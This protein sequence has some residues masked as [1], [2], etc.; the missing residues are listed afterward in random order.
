[1]KAHTALRI[2][3]LSLFALL[4]AACAAPAATP[5]TVEKV[6][7]VEKPVVVTAQVTQVVEQQVVVTPTPLPKTG[8]TVNYGLLFSP[9][10]MDPHIG[11]SWDLA[12]AV[13]NVYDPL[14]NTD[15]SGNLAPGL[16]QSWTVSPDARSITFK[17]RQG[18]K[19]HDGTP[20]NA[21]A[22]KFSLD[23]IADPKT[24]SEFAISLI[25][26]Y[27]STE[28]LDDYTARVN[29]VRPYAPFLANLSLP[30][31]AMVSPAA[32]AK[33]GA[34]YQMHQVGTGPYIFKEYVPDQTL[35]LVRNPD[36][37]WAP[38]SAQHQ[39]AAY[40]D[41]IVFKFIPDE[42]ARIKALQAGD[43]NVARELPPEQAPQ[44]AQD[45]QF[46][47]LV[48]AEP[49]QTLQFFMNTKRAP[50]D[51]LRV[52]Q[53]LLYAID[54]RIAANTIF[55]G[56]F[57]V[58]YGPLAQNT[59]GYDPSL[60]DMYP[61]DLAKAKALLQ[62]A[63]WV[64]NG[65]GVRQKNGTTL[66]LDVIVQNWGHIEE[67]SQLMQGELQ[68]VGVKLNLQMMSFPAALQAVSDGK[69]DLSP[70]GGGGWDPDVLASYFRSDA[71]FN[72]SKVSDAGLDKLLDQAGSQMNGDAR[73]K[74]YQQAQQVIMKNALIIPMLSDG[75]IV[76]INHRIK[77]LTYD[78]YGLWPNFYDAYIGQ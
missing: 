36:Y 53:A 58:A 4:L 63:G 19:F 27:T 45:P 22:V 42:S 60:K 67:L 14:V 66:T 32:V 11:S 50:L 55:Q 57:P 29:F 47:L 21:A 23:R 69:Y 78:R 68:Q 71:Y 9:S 73:V 54:P 48:T 26:S 10:S 77:G 16:A 24:Q 37:N 28:V 3:S 17:L 41:Q 72:W 2:G 43:V 13:A 51:D 76:G 61:Y 44:L 12:V 40:L 59:L 74:L 75:Q 20:F 52:R 46:S 25:G 30:Y 64:D 6:V 1:M 33:W 7:T 35:T 56:Y 39:G 8:G 38:P 49:G 18:V 15:S 62:D 65:S 5:Q 31:L 70:Y 34:D